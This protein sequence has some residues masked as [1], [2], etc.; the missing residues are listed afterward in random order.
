MKY[1]DLT[2]SR[3]VKMQLGSNSYDVYIAELVANGYAT[4]QYDV[5]EGAGKR[6]PILPLSRSLS[7][8]VIVAC[9]RALFQG[10]FLFV[11]LSR[12]YLYF[13]ASL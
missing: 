8:S 10:A 6:L 5:L 1:P 12:F 3:P 11:C 9:A 4:I 13:L 7:L 2:D